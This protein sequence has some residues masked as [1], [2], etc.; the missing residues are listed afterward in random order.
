MKYLKVGEEVRRI[1]AYISDKIEE[2]S[3]VAV[4]RLLANG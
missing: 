1:D 3:R 4:Q 2:L